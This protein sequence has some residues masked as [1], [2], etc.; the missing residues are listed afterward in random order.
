MF[1]SQASPTA[2]MFDSQA[3]PKRAVPAGDGSAR[4]HAGVVFYRTWRPHD[5]GSADFKAEQPMN[6]RAELRK[7][8]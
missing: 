3:S 4:H 7:Y 8:S 1:D 6:N 5:K 2:C